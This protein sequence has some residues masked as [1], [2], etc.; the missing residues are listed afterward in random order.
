MAPETGL[1]ARLEECVTRDASPRTGRLPSERSL[2]QS[3][4]VGRAEL[5]KALGVLEDQGRIQRHVGR[6]TFLTAIRET[7]NEIADR[8]SLKTSPAAA[9]EARLL[10]EPGLVSLAAEKATPEQIIELRRLCAEMRAVD[11]WDAYAELDWRF[12][13]MIAAATGNILLTEIQQLLNQVRRNVVWSDL[14]TP[15]PRPRP[16]YHSFAEHEAIV[17]AIAGRDPRA[18]AAAMRGHLQATRERLL[19][20]LRD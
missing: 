18:A 17:A 8:V 3:L 14:D 6:G 1:L 13:N 20:K 15:P 7:A 19:D 16:D 9:M 12:H 11:S 5:R 10:V 4:G 2:A